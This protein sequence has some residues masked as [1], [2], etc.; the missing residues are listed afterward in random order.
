M[1]AIE[2]GRLCCSCL[3]SPSPRGDCLNIGAGMRFSFVIDFDPGTADMAAGTRGDPYHVL[4]VLCGLFCLRLEIEIQLS[5][6]I[7]LRLSVRERR[8]YRAI[9]KQCC[10]VHAWLQ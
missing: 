6:L 1:T 5:R 9:H 7:R 8:L 10:P 3:K 2:F 4:S